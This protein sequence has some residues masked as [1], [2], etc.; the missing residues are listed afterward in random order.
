[1][2]LVNKVDLLPAGTHRDR[3]LQWARRRAK[4]L[5]HHPENLKVGIG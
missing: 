1:M 4:Q 2:L 5:Y 3:V